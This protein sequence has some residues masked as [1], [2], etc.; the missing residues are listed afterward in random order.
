MERAADDAS[1]LASQ[2]R[3]GAAARRRSSAAPSRTT[4]GSATPHADD[5]A[6]RAAARLAGA[7]AFVDALPDGYETASGTAGDRCRQAKLSASRSPARSLRDAE[8]VVLDEPT[9]NLD[10]ANAEAIGGA[11]QQLSVGRTVLV[12]AHRPELARRADRIV[13]LANGRLVDERDAVG[14]A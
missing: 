5:A 13:R 8:L 7:D 6:V 11:L 3:L 14:A 2:R 4:S 1:G 10:P 9:A 12:I